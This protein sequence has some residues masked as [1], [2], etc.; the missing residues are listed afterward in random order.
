MASRARGRHCMSAHALPS[1]VMLTF[2]R[3]NGIWPFDAT[4]HVALSVPLVSCHCEFFMFAEQ[5]CLS[6]RN[7]HLWNA[8]FGHASQGLAS[9]PMTVI[10]SGTS[11]A[12]VISRDGRTIIA[13]GPSRHQFAS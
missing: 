8:Q 12:T 7:G 5:A 4:C 13:S 6:H 2:V 3:G 11:P 9:V 1:N 10:C